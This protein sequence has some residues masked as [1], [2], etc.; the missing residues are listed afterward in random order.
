M[1][2]KMEIYKQY[3]ATVK[4][5][6]IVNKL[7]TCLFIMIMCKKVTKQNIS[8]INVEFIYCT[9]KVYQ[10]S[11]IKPLLLQLFLLLSSRMQKYSELPLYAK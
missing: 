8:I 10:H 4:T 7:L 11:L 2:A 5:C 9:R 1:C 6:I 3:Y